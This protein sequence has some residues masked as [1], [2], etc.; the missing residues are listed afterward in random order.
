LVGES[1]LAGST[2][3]AT[4]PL[5]LSVVVPSVSVGAVVVVASGVV[6]S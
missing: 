1:S 3:F 2:G 5:P 6:S 4:P